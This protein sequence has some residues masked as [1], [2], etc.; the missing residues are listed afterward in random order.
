MSFKKCPFKC[1]HWSWCY[2]FLWQAWRNYDA[3]HSGYIESDELKVRSKPLTIQ[4]VS[5]LMNLTK[6]SLILILL[7]FHLK[8][9]LL[10][11]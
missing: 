4:M 8:Y 9:M 1:K 7:F 3:D 2:S 11:P 5:L 10:W 6:F